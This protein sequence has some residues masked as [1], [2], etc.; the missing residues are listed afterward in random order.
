MTLTREQL[1]AQVRETMAEMFGFPLASLTEGSNIHNDLDLDS[2]DLT[3][4]VIKI[5]EQVGGDFQQR[6]FANVSTIGEIADSLH[7]LLTEKACEDGP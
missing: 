4:L 2:I 5:R 6:Y 7:L 3:D 1:L